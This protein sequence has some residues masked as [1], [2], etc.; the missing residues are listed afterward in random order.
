LVAVV[1]STEVGG[2]GS[3]HISAS[4]GAADTMTKAAARA[5]LDDVNLNDMKNPSSRI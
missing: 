3:E 1:P 4:A 2:I 5:N